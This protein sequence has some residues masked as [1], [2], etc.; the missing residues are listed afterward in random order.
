[1]KLQVL[2][3]NFSKVLT[4]ASRFTNIRAQLPVLG[5]IKLV[6][7]KTRLE[8]YSTNLEISFSSS[9]GAKVEKEGEITIPARQ[10]TEI[11][12]NLP[13]GTITLEAEK[14]QLQIES[15]N[16]KSKVSG[17]NTSDFP[18]IPNMIDPKKSLALPKDEF[19]DTLS[20]VLFASSVDESRPILTGILAILGGGKLVLVS[21]DGF[22]LS[23]K[24]LKLSDLAKEETENIRVI[25]PKNVLNEVPKLFAESETILFNF[26]KNEKQVLFGDGQTVLSSRVLEGEYPDFEKIIPKSSGCKVNLD[27][28]DFTRAVKLAS[29]FARDNANIVK[30]AIE[31]DLVS[32]SA[33][34]QAAGSQRAKVE[35]KVDGESLE[36]AFNYRFLE[37]FLH[38]AK[39]D[40][41]RVEFTNASAP[42]VFCDPTDPDFLH[43]IMPVKIQ[44]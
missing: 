14:E 11:I 44:G 33:E 23:M 36:I 8:V 29:V 28:E 37:D 17:M 40:D 21:T 25:L 1:M 3:E 9:V 38:I 10:L 32:V 15:S 35:A 6:A 34:S 5:N 31:K 12:G 4:N 18:V 39:S 41:V 22:R 16:F 2:Q 7:T 30:L 26:Q 20:G 19:I 27:K 13:K 42:G 24:K 43:L